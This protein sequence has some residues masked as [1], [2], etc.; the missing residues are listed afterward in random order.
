MLTVAGTLT[1]LI[2]KFAP[3]SSMQV[4]EHVQVLVVGGAA[5]ARPT[6][7]DHRVASD[8]TEPGAALSELSS[9]G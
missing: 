8:G 2:V 5:G 3:R 1:R 7:G 4:R 9:G 6:H